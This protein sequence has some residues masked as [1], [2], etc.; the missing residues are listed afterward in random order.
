MNKYRIAV[1]VRRGQA[2]F[3]VDGK[4]IG[5]K[6]F[7]PKGPIGVLSLYFYKTY[8]IQTSYRDAPVLI[9]DIR[10]ATYSRKEAAPQAEEDL[11]RALGGKETSRGLEITLSEAILFD[12][13]KWSL[14]PEAMKYLDQLAQLAQIRS[15]EEIYIEG[16]TDNVGSSEFNQVLSELRAHVVALALAQQGVEPKRLHPK[17]LGETRPVASNDTEQGRAQ[18]RRVEVV[19]IKKK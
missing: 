14:K 1:Q 18:N 7:H 11:I 10:L 15:E 6:P 16:H 4:R 13:G 2:R 5:H 8:E 17:G 19:F 3:F 12:F 9:T